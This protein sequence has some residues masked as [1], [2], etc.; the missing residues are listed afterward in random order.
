MM[1]FGEKNHTSTKIW[2]AHFL[3]TFLRFCRLRG[4]QTLYISGTDEYGTATE[5]KA[6]LEGTTPEKICE[7]FFHLQKGIYEWFNIEFDHF[8]RTSTQHQTEICQDI[9]L[10]LHKNGYTSTSSLDQLLCVLC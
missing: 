8:G 4:Y 9:F 6:L 7:K 1:N 10:K 5:M 2:D 3:I